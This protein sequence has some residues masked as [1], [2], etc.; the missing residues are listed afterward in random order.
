MNLIRNSY[1]QILSFVAASIRLA[2][3]KEMIA[4]SQLHCGRLKDQLHLSIHR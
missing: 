3:I 4:N 1:Y 2:V